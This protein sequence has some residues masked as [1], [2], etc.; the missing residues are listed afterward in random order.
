[1]N[2]WKA[3]RH[4]TVFAVSEQQGHNA[5]LVTGQTP[6]KRGEGREEREEKRGKRGE[7]REEREERR[8]KRG[9]GREEREGRRGVKILHLHAFAQVH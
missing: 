9:E 3:K 6:W 4:T 8:G 2:V 7:G 5:R 1:M